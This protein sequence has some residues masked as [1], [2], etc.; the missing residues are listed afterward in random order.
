MRERDKEREKEGGLVHYGTCIVEF[1]AIVR[2]TEEGD[3]LSSCEELIAIFNNLQQEEEEEEE[4]K[5]KDQH[6]R[7]PAGVKS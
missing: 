3:K 5:K 4:E 2:G 6:N 1:P 7:E